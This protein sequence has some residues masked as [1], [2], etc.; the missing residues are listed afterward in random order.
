MVA[1]T[2]EV[3]GG[4]T[5]AQL[6]HGL[7]YGKIGIQFPTVARD[8]SPLQDIQIRSETHSAYSPMGSR[9]KQMGCEAEH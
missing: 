9:V 2:A 1:E 7:D 4:A 8:F 3:V 5:T 6:G